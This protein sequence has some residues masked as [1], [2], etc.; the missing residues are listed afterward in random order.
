MKSC[1][2][3]GASLIPTVVVPKP[4]YTLSDDSIPTNQLEE[5]K[6]TRIIY[7]TIGILLTGLGFYLIILF[8]NLPLI[9]GV[10]MI[11]GT[12]VFLHGLGI[13][14]GKNR[15]K[16]YLE[17]TEGGRVALAGIIILLSSLILGFLAYA[18]G[19]ILLAIVLGGLLFL[20]GSVC[21]VIGA[22]LLT[23]ERLKVT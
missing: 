10:P 23:F 9:I 7:V 12:G 14:I 1:P 20:V 13:R 17:D 2:V 6:T 3:C 15:K 18:F 8:P 22:V 21:L 11:V 5:T 16:A 4:T 19:A